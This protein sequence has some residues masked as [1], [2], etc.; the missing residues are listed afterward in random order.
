MG[1]YRPVLETAAETAAT[2]TDRPLMMI[3]GAAGRT[4]QAVSEAQTARSLGYHAVLLSLA[5]MKGA[6]E[7]DL[8]AHCETVAR[9]M[10]L[11][12]FYLQ[13]AVGG[14]RLPMSF[15]QRFAAIENVIG[16]KARRSTATRTLD[17]VHGVAA[18]GCRGAHLA[19]YGQ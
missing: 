4:S 3:A 11:I 9:E 8:I 16:I 13:P 6:S 17:V 5:A 18:A 14:M 15:W 12:G 2:W 7:D 1:L 19:L 10:P